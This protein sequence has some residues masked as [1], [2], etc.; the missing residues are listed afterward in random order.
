VG[1]RVVDVPIGAAEEHVLVLLETATRH[2]VV[3]A[4]T[5]ERAVELQPADQF[6]TDRS[7]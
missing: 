5:V 6:G 7:P 4:H 2:G 1:Q 3:A